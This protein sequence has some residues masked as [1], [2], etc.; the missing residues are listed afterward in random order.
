MKHVRSHPSNGAHGEAANDPSHGLEGHASPR[1]NAPASS[2]SRTRVSPG[3]GRSRER[4]GDGPNRCSDRAYVGHHTCQ[5]PRSDRA[6]IPVVPERDRLTFLY[7]DLPERLMRW[8]KRKRGIHLY[9][10]L[11]QFAALRVARALLR[12][13]GSTS[14]GTSRSRTY[15]SGVRHP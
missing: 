9:Y 3:K 4:L 13:K 1:M 7:V 5:Q 14:F 6:L 11:W 8:K 15:G 12:R 2:S 10:L